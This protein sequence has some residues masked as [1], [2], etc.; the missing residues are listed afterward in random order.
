MKTR[1]C[2]CSILCFEV[3]LVHLLSTI[4]NSSLFFSSDIPNWRFLV[5]YTLS[6]VLSVLDWGY[7]FLNQNRREFAENL[8]V[9]CSAFLSPKEHQKSS[10]DIISVVEPLV[11]YILI[12]WE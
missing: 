11:G 9:L 2:V 6:E 8:L 4:F 10:R 1:T 12:F 5:A 3:D 7:R